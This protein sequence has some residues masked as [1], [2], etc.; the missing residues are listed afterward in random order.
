MRR[1]ASFLTELLLLLREG[2][3]QSLCEHMRSQALKLLQTYQIAKLI[4]N[5]TVRA[6]QIVGQVSLALS[7]CTELPE[8]SASGG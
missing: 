1:A 3:L 4:H 7:R 6:L 8:V 5:E 2:K